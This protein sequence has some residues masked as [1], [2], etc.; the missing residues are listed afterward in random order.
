MGSGPPLI[1]LH[2]F[3]EHWRAFAPMMERFAAS[4]LCIAP[5]QRGFGRS[6]KP[7]LVEDY[8]IDR[9]AEDVA[10]LMGALGLKQ[11]VLIAHDWGGLVAWHFGARYPELVKAMVIFN[12]PHPSGLQHALDTDPAQRAASIYAAQFAKP[13]SHVALE[14]RSGED[15]WHAFFARDHAMGLINAADKEAQIEAWA[16][17]GAWEAMTNWYRASGFEFEGGDERR[18]PK[19]KP[20]ITPTLLVWGERDPLFTQTCLTALNALAPNCQ[21][22]RVENGSH[23]VFR[24]DLV[25]C[26]ELVSGFLREQ[27]WTLE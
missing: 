17:E 5:D 15:L 21:L 11:V 20:I 4:H 22:Y 13:G 23:C 7:P 25:A 8:H 19:P 9:L 18:R 16:R 27:A 24:E 2:G 14:A 3:P 26:T 12:A 10:K 6:A 1:F